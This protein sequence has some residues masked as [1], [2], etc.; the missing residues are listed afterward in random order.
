MIN[1]S[2]GGN[3]MYNLKNKNWKV[4]ALCAVLFLV[5]TLVIFLGVDK[6]YND[7][8]RIYL[9]TL[10]STIAT[11][12]L[13]NVLWEIIAKESFA[14]SLLKLVSISNNIEASG[15]ETV[16]INFLD[17]NW[18]ME[19]RG[20][21]SFWVAVT[22][23]TTWRESNRSRLEDFLKKD[24]NQMNVILPDPEIEANM[25]EY[26]RRFNFEN[27]K[28]KKRVEEAIRAFYK[29]GATVYLYPGTMQASY[30]KLDRVGIMSFYNHL[31][32]KGSVPAI[33]AEEHGKFYS[34]IEKDLNAIHEKSVKVTEVNIIGD[35]VRQ[36][37]IRR[38]GNE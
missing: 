11:V 26:D 13:A 35:D 20:T 30:Y 36:I 15:I 8:C 21:K 1:I 31:Q 17:I 27:G 12:L 32:E 14:D 3:K 5:L 22:Y 28:T 38:E 19:L 6:I 16:Y 24:G 7:T 4:I 18:E 34:F 25:S 10:L 37:V 2:I 33:K 9:N 29:L 23:A